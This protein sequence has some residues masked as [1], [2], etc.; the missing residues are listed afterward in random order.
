MQRLRCHGFT[1]AML[2]EPTPNY[3]VLSRRAADDWPR[4]LDDWDRLGSWRQAQPWLEV[5]LRATRS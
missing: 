5:G 2:R 4:V 1:E 3:S